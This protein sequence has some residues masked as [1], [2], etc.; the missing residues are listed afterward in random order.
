MQLCFNIEHISHSP[1][2]YKTLLIDATKCYNRVY[3]KTHT[4]TQIS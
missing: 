2:D 3:T 4:C 1:S